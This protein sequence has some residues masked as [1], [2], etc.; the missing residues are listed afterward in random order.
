MKKILLFLFMSIILIVIF[1]L[2]PLYVLLFVW[3][4]TY[5]NRWRYY[6]FVLFNGF[7]DIIDLL[8]GI[9]QQN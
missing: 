1:F 4:S 8:L 2:M 7:C 6:K 5:R 9:E 3:D